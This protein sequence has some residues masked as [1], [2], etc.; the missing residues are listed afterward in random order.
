MKNC[1]AKGRELTLRIYSQLR[2]WQAS[3]RRSQKISAVCSMVLR[4]FLLIYWICGSN[5][6]WSTSSAHQQE[7]F[8]GRNFHG[9]KF[10]QADFWS[11]KSWKFL[12]HENFPLYGISMNKGRPSC[13]T[14]SSAAQDTFQCIYHVS[15]NWLLCTL[16]HH[17]ISLWTGM[18]M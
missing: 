6:L 14:K 3:Y 1:H 11:R 17:L 15:A 9:N 8:G 7:I 12:P 13:Y 18:N 16:L 10:S 5:T 4:E 2:W